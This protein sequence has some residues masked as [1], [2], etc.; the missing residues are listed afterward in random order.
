MLLGTIHYLL[1]GCW[2]LDACALSKNICPP[3]HID[4][5]EKLSMNIPL[6]GWSAIAGYSTFLFNTTSYWWSFWLS[7]TILPDHLPTGDKP[8]LVDYNRKSLSILELSVTFQC[9]TSTDHQYCTTSMRTSWSISKTWATLLNICWG[10]RFYGNDI[11][12]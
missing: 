11:R 5:G 9:N 6:Y 10:D 7:I 8:D 2:K 4:V 12:S 3:P 1:P